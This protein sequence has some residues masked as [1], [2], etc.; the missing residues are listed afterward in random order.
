MSIGIIR[1]ELLCFL[2]PQCA[3][4]PFEIRTWI[5]IFYVIKA[6]LPH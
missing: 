3:R 1:A 6:E 5:F 2:H 4:S